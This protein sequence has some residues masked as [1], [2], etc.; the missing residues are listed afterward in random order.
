[1]LGVLFQK[2]K[3]TFAL[4]MF[5]I[6]I[7]NA[8]MCYADIGV[9]GRIGSMGIGVDV[10]KQLT[11]SFSLRISFSSYQFEYDATEENIDYTFELDIGATGVLIDW[12]PFSGS[13]RITSGIYSNS[14]TLVGV[15]MPADGNY[16][17]GDSSYSPEVIGDLIAT[18]DLGSTAPYI[19]LGWGYDFGG[20]G[21]GF[22]LDVGVLVQASP[23]VSLSTEFSGGDQL[24]QD[25]NAEAA[26]LEESLRHFQLYPVVML[27]V[28]YVF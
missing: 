9:G 1:M 4:V 20:V 3:A 24:Q 22:V 11:E 6:G 25:L 16:G 23:E 10:S 26:E 12:H 21:I 7:L 28:A 19:G 27:G 17:I 13:M 15:A 18:I 2:C 14:T 5:G 8:S